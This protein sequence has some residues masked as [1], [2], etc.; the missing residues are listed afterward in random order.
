MVTFEFGDDY[1]GSLADLVIAI[2]LARSAWEAGP[3]QHGEWFAFST[4][5][6]SALR[7]GASLPMLIERTQE[8]TAHWWQRAHR[9]AEIR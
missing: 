1:Y 9:P 2:R 6:R 5:I 8:R 7:A 4:E 3:R